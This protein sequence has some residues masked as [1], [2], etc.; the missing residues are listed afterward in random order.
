MEYFQL[1]SQIDDYKSVMEMKK[2]Y[3]KSSNTLLIKEDCLLLPD[4]D[5]ELTKR[6]VYQRMVFLCKAG[7]E[8]KTQSHGIRNSVTIKKNCPVKVSYYSFKE[9]MH[10]N[11]VVGK[12]R[13][14]E[15]LIKS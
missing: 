15:C 11:R 1:N 12:N 2:Q 10:V 14:R 6:C 7:P 9:T 4:P 5:S 3:E 13:D 8:R